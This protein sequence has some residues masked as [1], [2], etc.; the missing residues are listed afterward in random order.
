M[1]IDIGVYGDISLEFLMRLWVKE[2][3]ANPS[4]FNKLDPITEKD[5][6]NDQLETL[7]AIWAKNFLYKPHGFGVVDDV[8]N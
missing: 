7:E 1:Y 2:N 3:L 6:D 5:S 4:S 8:V